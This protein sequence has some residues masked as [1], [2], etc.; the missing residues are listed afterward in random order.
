MVFT[1]LAIDGA[2]LIDVER[3]SDERGFFARTWCK[4]EFAQNGLETNLLQCSVSFNRSTGT[5][6]GMHYQKA[7]HGEVKLVRCTS[8]AIYDAIVDLRRE[9]TT[10]LQSFGV[11]L[12]AE[13]RRMLYIPRGCAHG[14]LTLE[15]NSEVFYQMCDPYEPSSAAGARWND[16]AFA[17]KWPIDVAVIIDRDR[18][19]PDYSKESAYDG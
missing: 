16:P 1:P 18:T 17:I 9:S 14:F 3:F 4:D 19:Y 7:P 2:F 11:E 6:R 10:Y 15:D 8:G 13:N 12:S 5:L